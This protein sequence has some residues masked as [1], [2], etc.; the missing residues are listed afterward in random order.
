MIYVDMSDVLA[1]ETRPTPLI[2]RTTTS[3]DF[4]ETTTDTEET[5]P[6][7][8][9][10]AQPEELK[11][12]I[13]DYSKRYLQVHSVHP[14]AVGQYIRWKSVLHKIIKV[15]DYSDYGYYETVAEQEK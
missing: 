6:A 12:D 10:V 2:T 3:V 4:V 8:V 14:M 5:I 9:Q 7:I 13:V 11:V 15:S 1:G